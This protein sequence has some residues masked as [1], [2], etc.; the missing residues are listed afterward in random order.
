MM[1]M[2]LKTR[3]SDDDDDDDD[4]KISNGRAVSISSATGGVSVSIR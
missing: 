3:S 2:M 4:D 1:M